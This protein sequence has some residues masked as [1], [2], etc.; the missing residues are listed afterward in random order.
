MEDPK[1]NFLLKIISQ[2]Y[3]SYWGFP[4]AKPTLKPGTRDA[5][6]GILVLI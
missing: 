1:I 2:P 3:I 5:A 4:Q 6:D